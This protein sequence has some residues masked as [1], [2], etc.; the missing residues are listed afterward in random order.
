LSLMSSALKRKKKTT[1]TNHILPSHLGLIRL[2]RN[3]Q[4]VTAPTQLWLPES[5]GLNR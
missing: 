5:K 4:K 3:F 2:H 1:K